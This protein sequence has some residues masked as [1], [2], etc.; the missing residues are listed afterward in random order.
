M[1]IGLASKELKIKSKKAEIQNLKHDKELLLD[2][3]KASLFGIN[4]SVDK[5]VDIINIRIS[6]LQEEIR[7]LKDMPEQ[8]NEQTIINLTGNGNLINTGNE[9]SINTN[10]YINPGEA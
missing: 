4:P 6:T 5:K 7:V 2:Q 9:N 3:K 8:E 1:P 10:T